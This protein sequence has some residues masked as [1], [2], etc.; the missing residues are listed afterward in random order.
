MNSAEI[1]IYNAIWEAQRSP[2]IIRHLCLICKGYLKDWDVQKGLAICWKCRKV[3]CPDPKVEEKKPE[4][5]PRLAQVKD[6]K[7]AIILD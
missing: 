4:P 1:E 7:Q 6:G 2:T 5:K 3:Y